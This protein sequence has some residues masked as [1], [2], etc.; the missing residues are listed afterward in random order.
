MRRS[1]APLWPLESVEHARSWEL[2]TAPNAE[3]SRALYEALSGR[4]ETKPVTI[5]EQAVLVRR[6]ATSRPSLPN[7]RSGGRCRAALAIRRSPSG[8][9]AN[10]GSRRSAKIRRSPK[11]ATAGPRSRCRPRVEQAV[12]KDLASDSAVV[13]RSDWSG[14]TA[15][16]SVS[17]STPA[18]SQR[19]RDGTRVGKSSAIPPGDGESIGQVW[20]GQRCASVALR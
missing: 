20:R 10:E 13:S 5:R 6:V 2:V 19:D 7:V 11:R 4:N 3:G 18:V 8:R 1:F 14:Q 9:R 12:L 16:F 17:Q 15:I